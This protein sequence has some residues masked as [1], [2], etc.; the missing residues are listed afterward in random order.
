MSTRRILVIAC[1]LAAVAVALGAFGAHALR[2]RLEAAD[3]L[4]HWE[5]AVR[6]Q[7]WHALALLAFGLFRRAHPGGSAVAWC[8]LVGTVCFS[9]S[10]YLLA[11]EVGSAVVWPFTP[12]GG[13]LLIAGWIGFAV[14]A[15]RSSA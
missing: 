7:M 2:E 13:L 3:Q 12:L 14:T 1:G 15:T 11:L 4:A 8:F 6:Y 5:T 10:I 9:G